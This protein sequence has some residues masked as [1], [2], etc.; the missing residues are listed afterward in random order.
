[1]KND[2]KVHGKAVSWKEGR[3]WG[4]GP[5][6]ISKFISSSAYE[7]TLPASYWGVHLFFH[8]PMLSS[9]HQKNKWKR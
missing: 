3:F 6:P 4:S 9:K 5:F 2:F 8:V 7:L 1:M